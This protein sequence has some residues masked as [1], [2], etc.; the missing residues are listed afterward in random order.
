MESDWREVSRISLAAQG[1]SAP[2]SPVTALSFD[3]SHELVWMGYGNGRVHSFHSPDMQRYTRYLGHDFSTAPTG[4]VGGGGGGGLLGLGQDNAVRQFQFNDRGVVSLSAGG[5]HLST[6][7]GLCQWNLR[8]EKMTNLTCMS[9][10][11]RGTAELLVGGTQKTLMTVNLDRGQVISEIPT[12][13]EYRV[14]KRGS[15]LIC[16]GTESGQ[17]SLLDMNTFQVIKK[18][19]AHAGRIADLDTQNNILL[20]CG[21]SPR[22]HN[23]MTLDPIVNV[24]DLRM[25]RSLPPIPF[26]AGAAFVRMHPKMST[27]GIIVSQTGQFHVVDIAN[28]NAVTLNHANTAQYLTCTDLAPSG[29]A[30]VFVDA[31]NTAQLWGSPDRIRF[32]DVATPVEWPDVPAPPPQIE[33]SDDTPLNSIGIPYYRDP[34]LSAWPTH[35]TFTVGK[36]PPKIDGDILQTMTP[37]DFGGYTK[38][39]RRSK[40]NQVDTESQDLNPPAPR[41]LS[42]KKGKGGGDDKNV[43]SAESAGAAAMAAMIAGG[44]GLDEKGNRRLFDVPA[45]YKTV[46]IKYSRFGVDDFDFEYYNRTEYSG[47]ETHIPNSYSNSLLQLFR[48]TPLLRNHSLQH[49]AQACYNDICLLCQMGFLFDML[50]KANGLNCQATNFLKTFSSHSQ[51]SALGLL[52]EETS[53]NAQVALQIQSLAR[54]LLDRITQD[55]KNLDKNSTIMEEILGTRVMT[56]IQCFNCGTETVRPGYLYAHDILYPKAQKNLP[57][58]NFSHVL[59]QSV[60]RENQTRGWCD[61]CRRYHNLSTRKSIKR[62][63]K[64]LFL[65]ATATPSL[66]AKQYWANN[67]FLPEEIGVIMQEDQFFCY[68]GEDLKRLVQNK[69]RVEVYELVGFVAEIRADDERNTHLVSFVN[70]ALSQAENRDQARWHLFNDFSVHPISKDEALDFTPLWKMPSIICFQKKA[71]QNIIDNS[72]RNHL[73]T[74]VLHMEYFHHE[75]PRNVPTESTYKLLTADEKPTEGTLVA[76]D[77]E[78]VALQQEEIEVK[79]DGSREVVRPSRSGLARVSVLRGSGMDEGVPFL[80]DYIATKEPVVDYLTDYSGIHPGDLDVRLSKHNVIPLKI[81]Y[82]R[83][84][85]LLNLGCIFIG[86]GLTKDFRTINIHV[87]KHQVQDTVQLYALKNSQRKLSLRFLAYS[88]LRIEIQKMTHDSIEDARTALRLY[89]KFLEYDDAGIFESILSSVQGEGAKCNFKVPSEG[90]RGVVTPVG[91]SAGVGSGMG[92]GGSASSTPQQAPPPKMKWGGLGGAS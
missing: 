37:A 38:N 48:F 19:P 49:T 81:A 43:E 14:M 46:E 8:H 4:G 79:A 30:L 5:L 58:P 18:L 57:L 54:F 39:P 86:H 23:N 78:F 80:D 41:F 59:K 51:A 15:R 92:G 76:L 61:K 11:N 55:D 27:T 88:V 74:S 33:W 56:S 53:R 7:R 34:L 87:P 65:N 1:P 68:Q 73:D 45:H 22:L 40:R 6:R 44:G 12:E 71:E 62:I 42:E 25:H 72:W 10:T 26:H 24:F 63:P 83:L 16:C 29:E 91:K 69:Q 21:F 36:L 52:E 82:K 77:A 31:E 17:V 28:H 89:K 66:D 2:P 84:W 60:E 3:N 64:V 32:T 85:L 90:V 20:T 50:E 35:L 9:Y 70:V 67:A 13:D 75:R 47:L